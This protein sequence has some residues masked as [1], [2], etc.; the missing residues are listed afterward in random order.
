MIRHLER[1]KDSQRI[2]IFGGTFDPIHVAHLIIAERV[3]DAL[4]LDAVL[5]IPCAI[6][7]HK[8][9]QK[10]ADAKDRYY[11]IELAISGNPFFQ[12]S[13]IELRREGIS[14]TIDT[15]REIKEKNPIE[16]E[17]FFL[18]IGA[19]NLKELCTWRQPLDIVKLCRLAVVRR[20]HSEII[21]PDFAKDTVVVECPLLE[22]SST[23]LRQM[24]RNGQSI[25]YL[26]TSQVEQYIISR[27]LYK[28]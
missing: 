26:V 16:R 8:T 3:R 9:E 21:I 24:V 25:R 22:I 7:P 5:F 12:V 18:I 4:C 13:D 14:Y 10:R 27:N 23:Q 17:N 2:G 19:D 11:M 20:P 6:P 15:L 28:E 1:K